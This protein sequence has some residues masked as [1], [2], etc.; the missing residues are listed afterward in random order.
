MPGICFDCHHTQGRSA[1][2]LR[3]WGRQRIAWDWDSSLRYKGDIQEYH[4]WDSQPRTRQESFSHEVPR[5]GIFHQLIESLDSVHNNLSSRQSS[6]E[7]IWLQSGFVA[8]LCQL[9][10]RYPWLGC[11][12]TLLTNESEERPFYV[13]DDWFESISSSHGIG[14]LTCRGVLPFWL[15]RLTGT[16][17]KNSFFHRWIIRFT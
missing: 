3:V 8:M 15:W 6:V 14:T 7:V 17:D 9:R 11:D 2:T 12:T 13:P 5:E 16:G 1:G 4:E 10:L